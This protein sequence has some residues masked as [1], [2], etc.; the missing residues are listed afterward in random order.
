MPFLDDIGPRDE[1]RGPTWA[2]FATIGGQVERLVAVNVG[3]SLV[4]APGVVA[5]AFAELP[6]W[7]RIMLGLA[8]ASALPL[9]TA[10]LFAL[11]GVACREQ[12]VDLALAKELTRELAGRSV[13][14]LAPLYGT[15]GVLVWAGIMAG[16]AGFSALT[17]V[18][19]LVALLWSVC[20]IYWGPLFVAQPHRSARHIART[21]VRLVTRHPEQSLWTWVMTA[22]VL[23]VGA[24]SIAGLVLI[25]PVLVAVLHA[26][27][28]ERLMPS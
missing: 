2:A 6:G 12:H 27:R 22:A 26:H 25:V 1:R 8:S 3:W 23:V 20:A 4:A 21:S 18:V 24:V 14:V 13:R 7:L 28:L 5:L 19:T 9:A 15:F 17:T 16:M 11:A 10:A